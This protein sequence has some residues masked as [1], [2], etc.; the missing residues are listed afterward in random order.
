[1]SVR[2]CAA[3]AMRAAAVAMAQSWFRIDSS[4]VSST[5]AEANVPVTDKM[6]DP[7]K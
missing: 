3:E 2:P 1:M 7:G 6:G 5:T 4:R